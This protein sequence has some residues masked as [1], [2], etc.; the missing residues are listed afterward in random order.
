MISYKT[1]ATRKL[2][3]IISCLSLPTICKSWCTTK[4]N[5]IHLRKLRCYYIVWVWIIYFSWRKRHMYTH[6][7]TQTN[8]HIYWRFIH[9]Y[10]I[11][12]ELRQFWLWIICSRELN[13]NTWLYLKKQDKTI[14]CVLNI[15]LLV[16]HQL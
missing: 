4:I 11:P 14:Y 8:K 5:N 10:K 15:V 7:G 12:M 13:V 6:T 2:R 16:T 3:I 9:L 1:V